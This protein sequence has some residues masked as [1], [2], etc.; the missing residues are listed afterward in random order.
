MNGWTDGLTDGRTNGW[1]DGWMGGWMHGWMDGSVDEWM[2]GW[3]DA[4]LDTTLEIV[5]NRLAD[6]VT[7]VEC[8]YVNS[9][10][11][12]FFANGNDMLA[13]CIIKDRE[14]TM[15][16]DVLGLGLELGLGLGLG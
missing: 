13:D 5:P 1:M 2:H 10:V 4:K 11:N 8:L 6:K 15:Q 12:L 14:G 16:G 7:K 9:F 3:M